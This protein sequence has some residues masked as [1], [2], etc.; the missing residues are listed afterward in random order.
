MVE[1]SVTLRVGT[2]LKKE[3]EIFG[4]TFPDWFQ[5]ALD[6]AYAV[7]EGKIFQKMDDKYEKLNMFSVKP[8]IESANQKTVYLFTA[9]PKDYSKY[10]N[11]PETF[12]NWL[13]KVISL[14]LIGPSLD[15][16]YFDGDSYNKL[17]FE[18]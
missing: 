17:V 16:Y 18:P 15:L 5:D 14:R 12:K 2:A 4:Q 3:T 6:F 9:T 10:G 13:L 7:E 11:N 8:F 1:N